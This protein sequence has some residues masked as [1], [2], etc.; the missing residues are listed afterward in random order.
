[1]KCEIKGF[2]LSEMK[3]IHFDFFGVICVTKS[4]SFG[5]G[6]KRNLSVRY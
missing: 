4:L 1:M 2:S 6:V 5:E 3:N